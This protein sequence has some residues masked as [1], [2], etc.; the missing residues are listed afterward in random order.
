MRITI[1]HIYKVAM[2]F[3]FIKM[4]QVLRVLSMYEEAIYLR[5]VIVISLTMLTGQPA[6]KEFISAKGMQ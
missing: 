4:S 5:A 6:A 3:K 1:A 2:R